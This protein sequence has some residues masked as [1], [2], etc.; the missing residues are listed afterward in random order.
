M[1]LFLAAW[2]AGNSMAGGCD[3]YRVPASSVFARAIHRRINLFFARAGNWNGKAYRGGFARSPLTGVWQRA[4]L[5]R[6]GDSHAPGTQRTD[7]P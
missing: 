2:R 1:T 5:A 7:F 6:A 4:N 3:F